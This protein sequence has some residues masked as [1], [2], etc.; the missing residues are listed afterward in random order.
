MVRFG[1]SQ[2]VIFVR[3]F[4]E[5]I[6][7]DMHLPDMFG[8]HP[9]KEKK[10]ETQ[11]TSEPSPVTKWSVITALILLVLVVA[12]LTAYYFSEYLSGVFKTWY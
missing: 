3:L 4:L 7:M 5:D 12:G 6:I 8:W 1:L 10:T 9:N 11:N 2:A